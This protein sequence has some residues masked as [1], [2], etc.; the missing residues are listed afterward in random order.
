MSTQTA[1]PRGTLV[2]TLHDPRPCLAACSAPQ[3]A[4]TPGRHAAC[5]GRAATA[6]SA[7]P[8]QQ[9]QRARPTP[10]GAQHP[11]QPGGAGGGA[12]AP[13]PGHCCAVPWP[14]RP[15]RPPSNLAARLEAWLSQRFSP[16][17][18]QAAAAAAA[19][20][21]AACCLHEPL[22]ADGGARAAVWRARA[23]QAHQ[24]CREPAGCRGTAA[25]RPAAAAG[26]RWEAPAA[27]QAQP[28]LDAREH[29][30]RRSG[31][32]HPDELAGRRPSIA[33]SAGGQPAPA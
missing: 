33:G 15:V 25:P 23:A 8:S 11:Q 4:G 10:P 18:A 19:P 26:G 30:R 20:R 31:F 7:R 6:V 28:G 2:C 24:H 27:H 9:R 14:G 29:W 5:A 12:A 3:A 21:A 1:G 16:G 13:G 17:I 32:W 22:P